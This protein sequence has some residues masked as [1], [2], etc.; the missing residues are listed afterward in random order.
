MVFSFSISNSTWLRKFS[1]SPYT[2]IDLLPF[3]HCLYCSIM[4]KWFGESNKLVAA[5]FSLAQK[6]APSIIFI[7][8]I[9]TFLKNRD[10]DS[11]DGA[12]G[13]MK[14]EFLTLWY[15]PLLVSCF[16]LFSFPLVLQ[17]LPQSLSFCVDMHCF[18]GGKFTVFL[19][20]FF[21]KGWDVN[22]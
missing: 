1:V 18:D 3:F 15:V 22:G 5:T 6:L 11:N 16:D 7:D 10:G 8:E 13:S 19:F 21:I 9:D 12:I 20:M 2:P 4:N 14:S 17:Y